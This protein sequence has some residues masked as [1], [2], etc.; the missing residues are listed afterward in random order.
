MTAFVFATGCS[1]VTFVQGTTTKIPVAP[2]YGEASMISDGRFVAPKRGYWKFHAS[3]ITGGITMRVLLLDDAGAVLSDLGRN[4]DGS[5][6]SGFTVLL[7][8]EGD[9]VWLGASQ[10]DP[11]AKTITANTSALH[12]KLLATFLAEANGVEPTSS[13]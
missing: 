4:V 7:L 5:V 9:I 6:E 12:S 13:F 8:D 10:Y 2:R 1:S 11:T 3:T